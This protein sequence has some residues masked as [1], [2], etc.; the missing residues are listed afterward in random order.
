[1]EWRKFCKK[2]GCNKFFDFIIILLYTITS[3]GS[4]AA[5]SLDNENERIEGNGRE[6][7]I[8][9]QVERYSIQRADGQEYPSKALD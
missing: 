6:K 4:L 3:I 5:S 2:L 1:L 7:Y 8:I 9:R